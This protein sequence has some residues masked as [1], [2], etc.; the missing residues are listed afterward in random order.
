MSGGEFNARL[1]GVLRRGR[2]DPAKI[3]R[4]SSQ[5]EEEDEERMYFLIRPEGWFF[6]MVVLIVQGTSPRTKRFP[7][8]VGD[9]KPNTT[10][11]LSVYVFKVMIHLSF[12][13]IF[14]W[15]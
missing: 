6:W 11:L 5:C 13:S 1:M 4:L 2:A 9:V 3:K 8:I 7:S 15:A 14:R 10:L 12:S